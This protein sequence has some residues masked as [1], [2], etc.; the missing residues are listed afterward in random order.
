MDFEKSKVIGITLESESG[1]WE[2]QGLE[3]AFESMDV[4]SEIH[5]IKGR[6]KFN[7]HV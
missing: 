6:I 7:A 1:K 5:V 3:E 2:T 4:A